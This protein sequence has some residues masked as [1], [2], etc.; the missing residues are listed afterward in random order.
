MLC[1]PQYVRVGDGILVH[2][3]WRIVTNKTE[4]AARGPSGGTVRFALAG[5]PTQTSTQI[6]VRRATPVEMHEGGTP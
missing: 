6:T 1:L 4:L 2:G 5:S 3:E